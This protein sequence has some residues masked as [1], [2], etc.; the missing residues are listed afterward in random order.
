MRQNDEGK[1]ENWYH[2]DKRGLSNLVVICIGVLLYMVLTNLAQVQA[3]VSAFMSILSPFIA[4]FVIAFLLN[5]PTN[6]FEER[7]YPDLRKSARLASIVTVYLIAFATLMVLLELVLPQVGDSISK[8]LGNM[9]F[10]LENL[11][12]MVQEVV[13]KFHLEGNNLLNLIDSYDDL[14]R[15]AANIVSSSI[16]NLFNFGVALGNGVVNA[17][18]AIVASIYMLAGKSRL[19]EQLKKLLYALLPT[20]NANRLLRISKQANQIFV[21]FI[22][23]KL[24]DS[25]II[26]VLC[27]VLCTIFQIPYAI[28]ISL[29]VGVTNIIPF[30]GPIIGA[31]PCVMI[32]FIVDAWAAL[33]FF[34]LI[35]GLQQFDG[36][37]LGPKILGDST[38]LS[39]IWVLVAIV[40]GGGLF[41]FAGMLLGV[42]TFAVLYALVREWANE[43]LAEKGIDAEGN[44]LGALP[45][46]APKETEME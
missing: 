1:G 41:G 15:Q 40:L 13:Q 29:I 12:T 4:G 16:P 34:V 8:L 21:G 30:F 33:R 10:Y 19:I 14:V 32:L 23:G 28:L 6:F 45:D 18:T 43:R 26:G 20:Q 5:S 7:V 42:P 11:N 2:L 36:N 37:I 39:A 25:A 17:F 31:V 44:N 22:N 35:I 27:F 38:G 9:S 24:I 3:A 46:E